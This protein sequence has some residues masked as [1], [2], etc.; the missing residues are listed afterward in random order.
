LLLLIVK[1]VMKTRLISFFNICGFCL[2]R[3]GYDEVIKCRFA[4][5]DIILR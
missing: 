4:G 2:L 1:T 3:T 5:W